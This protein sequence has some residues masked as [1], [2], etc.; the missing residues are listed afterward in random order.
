[1]QKDAILCILIS[2]S[3]LTPGDPVHMQKESSSIQWL[4]CVGVHHIESIIPSRDG[5]IPAANGHSEGPA[6]SAKA[7]RFC[8]VC[9]H[10]CI[11]RRTT[12][13]TCI[14]RSFLLSS[15]GEDAR[16]P[17][18]VKHSD[19]AVSGKDCH[20]SVQTW[21]LLCL[22]GHFSPAV[23]ELQLA[24]ESKHWVAY[25]EVYITAVVNVRG[26]LMIH[27]QICDSINQPE[28]L[29]SCITITIIDKDFC[30][31]RK[32]GHL[33]YLHPHY[34]CSG[35]DLTRCLKGFPPWTRP[36]N[37]S[38]PALS[39]YAWRSLFTDAP[40]GRKRTDAPDKRAGFFGTINVSGR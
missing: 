10:F 25:K 3:H 22:A 9:K 31:N 5:Q 4:P 24:I 6:R 27:R 1:M 17:E 23:I 16:I 33:H 18:N 11:C 29:A 28:S 34:G 14:W 37:Q 39:H 21:A 35:S 7:G 32:Q 20:C 15:A 8:T 38:V 19:A 26:Q 13:D 2:K 12:K 36:G 30:T 40:L